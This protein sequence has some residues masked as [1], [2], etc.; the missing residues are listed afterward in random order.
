MKKDKT[1]KAEKIRPELEDCAC[2]NFRKAARVV[3]KI[4]DEK[5]RPC[6]LRVT[7]ITILFVISKVQSAT[8]TNLAE[9][10]VLERTSLTRNLRPLEKQGLISIDSGSDQRRRIVT[11]TEQGMKFVEKVIPLWEETQ[12]YVVGKLGTDRWK[13]ILSDLSATI[14]LSEK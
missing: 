7:Q 12:E 6:G 14:S 10:L 4:Y 8:I 13:N 5:L 1:K 9:M 2:F 11:L 3:T